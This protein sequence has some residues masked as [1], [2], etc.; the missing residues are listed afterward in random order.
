MVLRTAS[1]GQVCAWPLSSKHGWWSQIVAVLGSGKAVHMLL[2]LGPYDSIVCTVFW[3]Q[4]NQHYIFFPLC[5]RPVT[6]VRWGRGEGLLSVLNLILVLVFLSFQTVSNRI[7]DNNLLSSIVQMQRRLGRHR[8]NLQSP[9]LGWVCHSEIIAPC[10]GIFPGS[11]LFSRSS[12][13][14]HGWCYQRLSLGLVEM[15]C[16]PFKYSIFINGENLSIISLSSANVLD[17]LWPTDVFQSIVDVLGA[18]SA[19]TLLLSHID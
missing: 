19:N 3:K 8:G 13:S 4:E 5:S 10:W 12:K 1:A 2:Y 14:P 17:G 11:K 16:P 6:F 15:L 9:V 7:A 18:V